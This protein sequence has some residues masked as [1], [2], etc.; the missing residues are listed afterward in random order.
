[1]LYTRANDE[2]VIN[3]LPSCPRRPRA[4]VAFS[5]QSDTAK[6][7][8]DLATMKKYGNLKF[9]KIIYLKFNNMTLTLANCRTESESLCYS[10]S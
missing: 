8:T 3:V 10:P 2:Q 9:S 6:S 1:M 4:G 7:T 5:Q